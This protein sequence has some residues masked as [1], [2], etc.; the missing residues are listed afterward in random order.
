VLVAA[1]V[2]LTRSSGGTNGIRA[3]PAAPTA[4]HAATAGPVFADFAGADACQ[5]CHAEQYNGW[6]VSTHGRAG[7]LPTRERVI[8]PFDGR[9]LRF[10]DA[11]VTPSRNAAGTFIFTVAQRERPVQTFEV[12]AV[13]GGGL[14]VG[15]GTQAYF[16]KFP[17]GT[18]R[19]LPFD[20]SRTEDLFFCNTLGRADRGWLPISPDIALADCGDWPPQRILG[21]SERFQTCQQCHGSQIEVVPDSAYGY[22][23]RFTTLAINCESCHGPGRRHIELARSGA[24]HRSADIGMRALGT[25]GKDQS[26]D[27]CFQCHAAKTAL[28]PDFLSGKPLETHFALKLPILLDS[29][30]F[31]DGRTR[32]FAYQEGHLAS[33]CYL[34]GSMT[35]VDCH[36]PHTQRY[37]DVNAR[38]LPGRF[39]DGQCTACHASKIEPVERHTRHAPGSAGSRC[40]ACHMPYLQ[41]PNVGRR[42]RYARSDHAIPI[43]RP[44]FD[45]RLGVESACAQCHRNRAPEELERQ[46][47]A[48]YGEIKPLAPAVL[49]VLAADSMRD[50]VRAARAIL[51]TGAPRHPIAE[52]TG[53]AQLLQRYARPDA[54]WLDAAAVAGLERLA[55]RDD[56]DVQALALALLHLASGNEPGVRDFLA[57]RLRR[58]G[59]RDQLVRDRW[60]WVL[61]VQ[62]DAYIAKREHGDGLAAYRKAEELAPRDPMVLRRLGIAHSRLR[63]YS[64]AIEHFRRSLAARPDQPQVLLELGFAYM[65]R[66][67]LDS[68]EAAYREVVARTPQDPGGHANLAL[69]F[70]RRNDAPAAIRALERA[71][72]LDPGLADAYFLLGRVYATLGRTREAASALRRGLELN[73]RNTAAQQLLESLPAR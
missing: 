9:Q 14:M 6:R 27:V 61:L 55:A 50:A 73:P 26:L 10:R 18:M 72:A 39:D 30:Y 20:Y 11:V 47:R 62:G 4:A 25:L 23:T 1:V 24:I 53:L 34:N 43:P 32:S 67:D 65:Q 70:L 5:E 66:G 69:V 58:L 52:T 16:S 3:L 60:V 28:E 12:H 22:E 41:Q 56:L 33:D 44:L 48:W 51:A 54:G 37:R 46:V 64:A 21:S 38:P 31:P 35:C 57:R 15:G 7:G 42:V 8:G 19:F 36:D 68:A 13:V 49:G 45:A 29:I 40:V 71:L 2:L 17:D 63:D 59:E